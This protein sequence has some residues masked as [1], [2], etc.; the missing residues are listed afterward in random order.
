MKNR[1]LVWCVGHACVV[2]IER[3]ELIFYI[4]KWNK[5]VRF[6]GVGDFWDYLSYEIE[7]VVTGFDTLWN[8]RKKVNTASIPI[9]KEVVKRD[10]E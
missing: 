7:Q 4:N 1:D 3:D 9:I 10:S 5:H 6:F 8:L 2:G